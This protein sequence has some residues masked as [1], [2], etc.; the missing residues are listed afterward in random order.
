MSSARAMLPK[1]FDRVILSRKEEDKVRANRANPFR[2][3]GE[4][5]GQEDLDEYGQTR[6]RI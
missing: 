5:A 3:E 1:N 4:T 2:R 6:T